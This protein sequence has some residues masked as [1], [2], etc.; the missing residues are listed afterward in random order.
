MS[1][2]VSDGLDA[3]ARSLLPLTDVEVLATLAR[4]WRDVPRWLRPL[5]DSVLALK[6]VSLVG[7]W[8]RACLE[9]IPDNESVPEIQ[10]EPRPWAPTPWVFN[11][12]EATSYLLQTGGRTENVMACSDDEVE[13]LAREHWALD[14]ADVDDAP[15]WGLYVGP[16]I[17]RPHVARVI[18]TL[19][20]ESAE[21]V[22]YFVAFSDLRES[23]PG[24]A[25]GVCAV[26]ELVQIVRETLLPRLPKLSE[27]VR[28][29]WSGALPLFFSRNGDLVL[30]GTRGTVA[31]HN[32]AERRIDERWSSL[33]DFVTTY[34]AHLSRAAPFDSYS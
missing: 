32:A 20:H 21:A 7:G 23:P 27:D 9:L 2:V 13:S 19:G 25:G 8:R 14:N 5:A 31:W 33:R 29:S 24:I 6:R 28:R 12:R 16:P 15:D 22:D 1:R 18:S 11:V 17:E 10:W 4:R 34:A 3:W 30:L 26:D